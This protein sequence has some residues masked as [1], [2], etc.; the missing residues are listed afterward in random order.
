ML[1]SQHTWPLP[2]YQFQEKGDEKLEIVK[3]N[4]FK[5]RQRIL[6]FSWVEDGVRSGLVKSRFRPIKWPSISRH[7]ITEFWNEKVTV[8]TWLSHSRIG[9]KGVV[10]DIS[11]LEDNFYGH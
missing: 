5:G 2:V 1:I 9:L 11:E 8:G 3:K 10:D 6:H 4:H 7:Y